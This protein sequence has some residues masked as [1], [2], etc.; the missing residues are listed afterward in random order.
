MRKVVTIVI[1]CILLVE[2]LFSM[3]LV[4]DIMIEE[5]I[6]ALLNSHRCMNIQLYSVSL[7][8]SLNRTPTFWASLMP[9]TATL[10]NAFFHWTSQHTRCFRRTADTHSTHTKTSNYPSVLQLISVECLGNGFQDILWL[11]CSLKMKCVLQQKRRISKS[12]KNQQ[13][14]VLVWYVRSRSNLFKKH[15]RKTANTEDDYTTWIYIQLKYNMIIN[16]RMEQ[17]HSVLLDQP[18]SKANEKYQDLK[19]LRSHRQQFIPGL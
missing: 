2:I 10:I 3:D 14:T 1:I 9:C 18:G 5:Y 12:R 13:K 11:P 4:I 15:I 7:K 17:R 6:L 16:S 8:V 19:T